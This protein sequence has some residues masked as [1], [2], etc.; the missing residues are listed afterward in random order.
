MGK[1]FTEAERAAVQERLRRAGLELFARKGIKGVSIRDLAAAAGI[2][3]GGF[4]TF[5]ENKEDFLCDL[6]ELRVREKLTLLRGR[7]QESLGDP[8]GFL[9][10]VFCSEGLHLKENKL[11]DNMISGTLAFFY[12]REKNIR[13]R[14]SSLYRAYLEDLFACWEENGYLVT[15]DLDGLMNLIRAAGILFSN[16]ALLDDAYFKQTYRCFCEAGV[17]QFLKVV[18][19]DAAG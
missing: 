14:V 11:F 4:Y 19:R 16:A 1:A 9:S 7:N 6:M 13:E 12:D 17:R 15:A 3:Q 8:A 18:P 2:A 5:Y 10:G